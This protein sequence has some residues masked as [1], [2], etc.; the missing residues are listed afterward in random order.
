MNVVETLLDNGLV[1]ED[2]LTEAKALSLTGQFGG[3]VDRALIDLGHV[4]EIIFN[5]EFG[6]LG[7]RFVDV[8]DGIQFFLPGGGDHT[9]FAEVG[10]SRR[11]AFSLDPVAEH[12]T[13]LAEEDPPT[14]LPR[15]TG[16]QQ[17]LAR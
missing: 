1:T 6:R 5:Q 13:T 12:A 11:G 9:D 3:R 8:L 17:R 4:L 2:Q 15:N 10:P 14:S 16:L 7:D